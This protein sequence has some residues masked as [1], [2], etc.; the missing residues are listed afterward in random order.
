MYREIVNLEIRAD[1]GFDADTKSETFVFELV[2][3][4]HV[5]RSWPM[6]GAEYYNFTDRAHA[7]EPVIAGKLAEVFGGPV[8]SGA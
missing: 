7:R 4:G 3:K 1:A 6:T 2:W 8:N 5:L